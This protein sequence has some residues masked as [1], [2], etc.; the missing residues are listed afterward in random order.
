MQ[1]TVDQVN[2]IVK[3][4]LWNKTAIFISWDDWGGWY[5]HVTPPNIEQWTDGSQF[6]YG[7][8]VPCLVLGP[9]AKGGYISKTLHSFVSI[10]KFCEEN[11]SVPSINQRDG[12]A[13][14]MSD[15]FDFTQKALPMEESRAARA[16]PNETGVTAAQ[17]VDCLDGEHS[18]VGG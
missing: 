6:R 14:N 16:V 3:G 15:C 13:D 11:F 10:V 1:W 12:S 2:A 7:S 9:Y 5:D 18:S 8:R 4:G 17:L